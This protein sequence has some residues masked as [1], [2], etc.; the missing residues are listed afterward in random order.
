MSID[1]SLNKFIQPGRI[2]LF[3]KVLLE[4][5]QRRIYRADMMLASTLFY[6]GA[7]RQLT[8]HRGKDVPHPDAA[9]R[10]GQEQPAALAFFGNY[11]SGRYQLLGDLGHKSRG[12]P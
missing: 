4:A 7:D 3:I 1:M 11:Q 12:G 9:G 6:A 2:E 8:V 5:A 10:P